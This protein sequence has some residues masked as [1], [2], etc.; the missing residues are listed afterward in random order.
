MK[1]IYEVVRDVKHDYEHEDIDSVEGLD[2][3]MYERIVENEFLSNS[4]YMSGD[5]DDNGDL[6]PFHDIITRILE[7]ART[8][9]EV[10]TKDMEINTLDED[11]YVRAELLSAYNQDWMVEK[12]IDKFHNDAIETRAKHGG[13]LVKVVETTDDIDLEIVDWT[14]FY[15]DA[16]DLVNGIKVTDHYYTP[17]ALIQKGEKMGWNM[18]AVRRVIKLYA[19]AD[20]DDD[21]KEQRETTGKYVLVREIAGVLERSYM[22][23]FADDE[24]KEDEYSYQ[25]H[26]VAGAEFHSE[27]GGEQGET[28]DSIELEQS[29]FYY[30][31]YKKRT[32]SGQELGIGLVERA[33]H[34]QIATN[35][36]AQQYKYSLDM[37]S[38]HV[39]QSAS[40]N[41]KGKNV[42]TNMKRGTILKHDDG[43]PISGV[44]MSPQ[45]LAHLDRYMQGWQAQVDRATNTFAVAT[46]EELP[47][48][49]PYRL[50]AILDQNAQSSF[51]LRRE[52]YG[53]FINQIYQERIIPFFIRQIK[54]ES[55]LSLK[56][57]PER[58]KQ[59]DKDTAQYQAD[60]E[61]VSMYL[62]GE[63]DDVPP[64][65]RFA[66][67]DVRREELLAEVD[68]RLKRGRSRR[69]IGAFP[70]GYWDQ[71]AGK[72]FVE[73][74]NERR[75][76]GAVLE[77]INN[78]LMQYA[79]LKPL[80]EQDKNARD[81]FNKILISSNQ[82]PLDFTESNPAAQGLPAPQVQQEAAIDQPE[83]FAAKPQ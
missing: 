64:A 17:S 50:G 2:F 71:V 10:D 4:R 82:E 66:V 9:E 68:G 48:G 1:S 57:T 55:T 28:L 12:H 80:L 59:I 7:N 29:P 54:K 67:M 60:K 40:K 34:S 79:K 6:K 52:E 20:Q 69:K 58:L 42:L 14:R 61:I 51:D 22:P 53:I 83:E 47:S 63:F 13:L 70:K 75:N 38:T 46:G 73:I 77:S 15:G 18:D 72:V 44:D 65:M 78:A 74:T 31:P 41:L 35:I 19:E 37:A 30:L 24:S 23:E 36:A 56:F 39:L 32:V 62:N 45:A 43:K 81:L 25:I 11:Y 33:R 27:K 5:T 3:N 8:A 26:Y 21:Y 49:T 76:K 16:A